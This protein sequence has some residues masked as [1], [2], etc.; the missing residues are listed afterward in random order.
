MA[1]SWILKGD[2][3]NGVSQAFSAAMDTMRLSLHVISK[4]GFG[5]EMLWPF[6]EERR[7]GPG[8]TGLPDGHEMSYHEALNTFLRSGLIVLL[9]PA[10]LLGS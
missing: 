4:A 10:W 6:E 2:E 1:E 3:T 7:F 9:V 8:G 5:R